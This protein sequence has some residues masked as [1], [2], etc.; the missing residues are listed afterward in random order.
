MQL[1]KSCVCLIL[2][3]ETAAMPRF[4][5]AFEGGLE[6]SQMTT[7]WGPNKQFS[8]FFTLWLEHRGVDSLDKPSPH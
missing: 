7:L 3:L 2:A 1:L 4:L 5:V 6:I 8:C